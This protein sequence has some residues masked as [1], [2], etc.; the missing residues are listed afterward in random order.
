MHYGCLPWCRVAITC[1]RNFSEG[2]HHQRLV[3]DQVSEMVL[4]PER[5]VPE[6]GPYDIWRRQ[7]KAAI[8]NVALGIGIFPEC[9]DVVLER[10][11]LLEIG[12]RMKSRRV[13]LISFLGQAV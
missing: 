12:A 13:A 6:C 7:L 9:L 1:A 10:I 3:A 8:V 11:E 4:Q 2:H 5:M